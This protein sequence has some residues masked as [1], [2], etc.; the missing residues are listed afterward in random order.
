MKAHVI[1]VLLRRMMSD[2]NVVY[3]LHTVGTARTGSLV[4]PVN[5]WRAFPTESTKYFLEG[6]G[7]KA[8]AKKGEVAVKAERLG[9][10]LL[11]LDVIAQVGVFIVAL[12]TIVYT[13]NSDAKSKSRFDKIEQ[14]LDQI[15]AEKGN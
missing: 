8:I 13:C 12:F 1:E 15:E 9:L 11:R 6:G 4:H 2:D 14:R 3:K 5:E 10:N 7:Y